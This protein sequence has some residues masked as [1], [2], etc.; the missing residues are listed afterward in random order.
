MSLI[1]QNE[2][3]AC[4]VCRPLPYCYAGT[5]VTRH[6]PIHLLERHPPTFS[7]GD[8]LYHPQ[9]I[10]RFTDW[11][12][13][14]TFTDSLACFQKEMLPSLL[15]GS[16]SIRKHD[17]SFWPF[18][19]FPNSGVPSLSMRTM[20]SKWEGIY[21]RKKLVSQEVFLVFAKLA[22]SDFCTCLH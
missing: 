10:F 4:E 3:E 12:L 21:L 2:R 19:L 18:T 20:N 5:G 14:L 13:P 11:P 9:S 1:H 17:K 15:S 16:F 8:A 6:Q 7:A 22:S